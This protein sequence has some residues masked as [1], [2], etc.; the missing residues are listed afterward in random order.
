MGGGEVAADDDVVDIFEKGFDAGVAFVEV[1]DDGNADGAGPLR[2][3][4]AGGG[5]EPV[6]MEDTR[7]G[8]PL[9]LQVRGLKHHSFV[10][11]AEHGALAVIDH[12][13]ILQAAG[14]GD[15]DDLRI[16]AGACECA[17]MEAG[18]IVV[19]EFADIARGEPPC[20][21]GDD[22]G[23]GLSAGLKRACGVFNLGAALGEDGKRDD[24]VGGVE[25]D[26]DE[27]NFLRCSHRVIVAGCGAGVA[28]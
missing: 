12:N 3:E 17:A 22:G 28:G 5:V 15:C 2:R 7:R 1:G 4:G 11:L 18:C 21:A 19:T 24:S 27:I 6:Y 10:A 25:A 13:E 20:L 9:A 14:A 23:G 26:A 8:D 16:D